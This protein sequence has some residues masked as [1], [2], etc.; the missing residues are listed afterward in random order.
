MG[1]LQPHSQDAFETK[2]TFG[3]ADVTISQT[4]VICERDVCFLPVHQEAMA[5]SIPGMKTE[6]VDGGH[7]AYI[8]KAARL[9]EIISQAG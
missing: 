8:S 5:A 7:S 4:F 2:T 3:A 9:A 6:R 1:L